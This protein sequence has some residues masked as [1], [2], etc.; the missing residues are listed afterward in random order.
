MR[1]RF[2]TCIAVITVFSASAIPVEL[3]AQNQGDYSSN[4]MHH[5][6]RLIDMGTFGGPQSYFNSLDLTDVFFF[7]TVF[8]NMAQ[9]RNERSAAR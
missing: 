5:H 8:Y 9:A 3:T 1:S 7:P 2:S 6:Y 4:H